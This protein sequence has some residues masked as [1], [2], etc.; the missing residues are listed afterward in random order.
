MNSLN[1]KDV[2]LLA[3]SCYFGW[4][5]RLLVHVLVVPAKIARLSEGLAAHVADKRSAPC[6]FSKVVTQVTAFTKLLA[7]AL[8][9]A[10]EEKL[11]SICLAVSNPNCLM[12]IHWD[13]LEF[14]WSHNNLVFKAGACR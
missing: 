14:L 5:A 13:T 11:D 7:T 1:F 8:I 4:K 3:L 6:V 2:C 10:S 12:P 9:L